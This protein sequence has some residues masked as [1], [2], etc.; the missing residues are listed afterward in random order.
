MKIAIK[1]IGFLRSILAQPLSILRFLL[2]I[3]MGKYVLERLNAIFQL[4]NNLQYA[5]SKTWFTSL[6]PDVFLVL[7]TNLYTTVKFLIIISA[8]GAALGILGRLNLLILAL[9]CFY[10][11]GVGEGIGVFD[12]HASLPSQVIFALALVPGSMTLSIDYLLLQFY[13]K[14]KM[15]ILDLASNPKWGLNLILALVAITYFSAGVSKLRY[16]HGVSWLDGSTLGFYLKE[17][18]KNYDAN[19]S[20]LIIGD[21]KIKENEKWKDEFGFIA[22]TYGNFQTKKK[23]NDIAEYIARN[24]F[25]VVGLSIGSVLFE[26]LAFI[27]FINTKYRNIYLISAII[28]HLSIGSLMGIS[29]RQY[30]LICFFLIDWDFYLR[31]V[32][33]KLKLQH[34]LNESSKIKIES[35]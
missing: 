26:L 3:V 12:H 17:R 22:H 5:L 15:K 32:L 34:L 8:F 2:S 13:Y 20:Q 1:L 18:T 14:R 23:L 21:S 6:L 35:R 28:F 31:F 11:F 10:V 16:G 7:D 27:V 19:E 4:E 9:S 25:L 30:R 29:F 33:K 24:K